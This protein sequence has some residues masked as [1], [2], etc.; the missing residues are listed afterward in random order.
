MN[1]LTKFTEFGIHIIPFIIVNLVRLGKWF[2]FLFVFQ[3]LNQA[4]QFPHGSFFSN[5]YICFSI[6]Q[7]G[8]INGKMDNKHLKSRAQTQTWTWKVYRLRYWMKTIKIQ[9]NKHPFSS[10]WLFSSSSNSFIFCYFEWHH[11]V[12]IDWVNPLFSVEKNTSNERKWAFGRLGAILNSKK[13]KKTKSSY[14]NSTIKYLQLIELHHNEW[15]AWQG[16]KYGI[17][18]FFC[19]KI[20]VTFCRE[21]SDWIYENCY[22]KEVQ[23]K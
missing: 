18:L 9:Q 15:N 3:L 17:F 21:I 19:S 20:I 2:T 14:L 11:N 22:G 1:V 8:S 16:F 12:L 6:L 13:Q 10:N 23:M 4:T 7:T 5:F